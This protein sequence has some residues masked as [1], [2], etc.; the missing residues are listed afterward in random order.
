MMECASHELRRTL[1]LFCVGLSVLDPAYGSDSVS[2]SSSVCR[3]IGI[4]GCLVCPQ[5]CGVVEWAEEQM[6]SGPASSAFLLPVLV[7]TIIGFSDH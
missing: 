1:F 7:N 4:L 3:Q 6:G 2:D 5:G